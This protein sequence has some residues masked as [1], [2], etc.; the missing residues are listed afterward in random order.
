MNN[1]RQTVRFADAV[2]A[3]AGDGYRVFV[4]VSSHPVLTA[5]IAETVEDAGAAPC[6]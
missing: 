1:V 4:E 6:W 2:R 5:A 3:L